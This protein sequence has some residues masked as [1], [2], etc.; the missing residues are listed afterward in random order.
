MTGVVLSIEERIRK[1][2]RASAVERA[3]KVAKA[4][5]GDRIQIQNLTWVEPHCEESKGITRSIDFSSEFPEGI[6]PLSPLPLSISI[7]APAEVLVPGE[8]LKV[9]WTM[10]VLT[11]MTGGVKLEDKAK[12]VIGYDPLSTPSVRNAIDVVSFL[13]FP[14]VG[15]SEDESFKPQFYIVVD[16]KGK[17]L[18]DTNNYFNAVVK[19]GD[20]LVRQFVNDT[21]TVVPIYANPHNQ[22]LFSADMLVNLGAEE[23]ASTA[24]DAG[25]LEVY[26][27]RITPGG[28]SKKLLDF[29]F[30]S[31]SIIDFPGSGYKDGGMSS[32]FGGIGD[33]DF[34]RG[35]TSLPTLPRE[36]G[37]SPRDAKK[38]IGDVRI[39]EG[40]AGEKVQYS[41]L[42]GYALDK[43]FGV[44][45]VRIRLLGVRETS[46]DAARDALSN[47][48][49]T[50]GK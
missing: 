11:R 49:K 38:E 21:R 4:L 26:V 29:G 9:S 20:K 15:A 18:G 6:T 10:P 33:F 8:D 46:Y 45:P 5:E 16:V 40:Q 34:S 28:V 32:T 12:G 24:A 17:H 42:E 27:H 13:P 44:Q 30:G 43:R 39:G 37:V 7:M 50:Y 2:K 22:Q 47:L 48:G 35:L 14:K 31:G 25:I 1:S 23:L 36:S 19:Y 3:W 41:S